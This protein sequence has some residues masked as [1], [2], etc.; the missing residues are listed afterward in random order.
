MLKQK[1]QRE[2]EQKLS[3]QLIR[4]MQLEETSPECD[5]DDI[6]NDEVSYPQNI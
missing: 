2:R 6:T 4:R 1:Q 3:K 5:K